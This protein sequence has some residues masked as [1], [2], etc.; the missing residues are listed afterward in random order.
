M[1]QV[2]AVGIVIGTTLAT[3]QPLYALVR[4]T[5]AEAGEERK[6]YSALIEYF[7]LLTQTRTSPSPE[8]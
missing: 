7:W 4:S 8:G 1:R 6:K 2:F 5:R 3:L